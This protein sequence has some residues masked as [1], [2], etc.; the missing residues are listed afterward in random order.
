MTQKLA[1]K[2]A[3]K[4][5]ARTG[6]KKAARGSFKILTWAAFPPYPPPFDLASES[7]RKAEK[8]TWL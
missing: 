5:M 3:S 2:D 4:P 6:L 7:D 8:F 1:E